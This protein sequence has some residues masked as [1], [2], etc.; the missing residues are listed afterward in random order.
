MT[1]CKPK[2]ED[3]HL[4]TFLYLDT[5]PVIADKGALTVIQGLAGH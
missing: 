5:S 2:N 3:P 4:A 1:G